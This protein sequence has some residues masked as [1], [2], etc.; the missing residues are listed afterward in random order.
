LTDEEFRVFA[1]VD[2]VGD[3]SHIKFPTEPLAEAVKGVGH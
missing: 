2:V 3:D 1:C